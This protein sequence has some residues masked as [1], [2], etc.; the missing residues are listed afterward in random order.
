MFV[1]TTLL[2]NTFMIHM[3]VGIFDHTTMDLNITMAV[4]LQQNIANVIGHSKETLKI[5]NLLYQLRN[6]DASISILIIFT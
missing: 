5:L 4:K 6:Y 2:V 3:K 1:I